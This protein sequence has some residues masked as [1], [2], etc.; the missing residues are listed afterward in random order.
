[1]LTIIIMIRIWETHQASAVAVPGAASPQHCSC[2]NSHG[3][4]NRAAR[5]GCERLGVLAKP[6]PLAPLAQTIPAGA[7]FAVF[8][9]SLSLSCLSTV[10]APIGSPITEI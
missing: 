1:M 7:T 10:L 8:L 5:E 4:Q 6:L 3:K 9:I 2:L